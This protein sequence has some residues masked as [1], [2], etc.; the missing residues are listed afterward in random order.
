[1]TQSKKRIIKNGKRY[2]RK[3]IKQRKLKTIKGGTQPL[4]P[5]TP[6][7]TNPEK[8]KK[9]FFSKLSNPFKTLKNRSAKARARS[10]YARGYDSK[11][12]PGTSPTS[13]EINR[14]YN[15]QQQ[16]L[17]QELEQSRSVRKKIQ[18]LLKGLEY[19]TP[20]TIDSLSG[21][22]EEVVLEQ[23]KKFNGIKENL[24]QLLVDKQGD[25][26]KLRGTSLFKE[27]LQT[28]T[29]AGTDLDVLHP[30]TDDNFNEKNDQSPIGDTKV[31]RFFFLFRALRGGKPEY[32]S[33]IS[34][35]LANKWEEQGWYPFD[36]EENISKRP[37][38]DDSKK[39]TIEKLFMEYFIKNPKLNKSEEIHIKLMEYMVQFILFV[40][41]IPSMKKQ[42][43]DG[44]PSLSIQES[45]I[46]TGFNSQ[47]W[48]GQDIWT[49]RSLSN[50]QVLPNPPIRQVPVS[51]PNS[52]V[53]PRAEG[54][55]DNPFNTYA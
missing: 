46:N 41:E 6:L 52:Q 13:N 38:I 35:D 16:K 3:Y 14:A 30:E 43:T 45:P 21:V 29:N 20:Q 18:T 24:K 33:T 10:K 55:E 28:V 19:I 44:G 53:F 9:S 15:N 54:L 17:E 4:T 48:G 7:T 27:T 34:T 1:M 26:A 5:I 51:S 36:K 2:K 32:L 37:N 22:V 42:S 11:N 47:N 39:Y 49:P 40:M 50:T 25:I 8:P 23:L 31:G 12:T